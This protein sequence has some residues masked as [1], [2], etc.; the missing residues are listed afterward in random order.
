MLA[1]IIAAIPQNLRRL[2]IICKRLHYL[3]GHH[4]GVLLRRSYWGV[5]IGYDI[6]LRAK[7]LNESVGLPYSCHLAHIWD[8]LPHVDEGFRYETPRKHRGINHHDPL[9]QKTYLIA[10]PSILH[11]LSKA[12]YTCSLGPRLTTFCRSRSSNEWPKRSRNSSKL[13]IL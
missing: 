11:H 4:R 8:I 1:K 10:K 13:K 9:F 12:K 2:H 3:K 7:R 6:P 5:R